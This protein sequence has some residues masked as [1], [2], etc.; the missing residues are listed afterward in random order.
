MTDRGAPRLTAAALGDLE[1]IRTFTVE[2][3]GRARWLDYFAG[4]EAVFAR[5]GADPRAGRPV[6]DLAPGLRL[7]VYRSHAIFFHENRR[8]EVVVLRVLH[9]KRDVEALRWAEV[10]KG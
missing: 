6:E 2:T 9:Q 4:M 5:L 8:G 3:W 7:V 1:N 10:M